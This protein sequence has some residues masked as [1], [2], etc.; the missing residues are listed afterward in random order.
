MNTKTQILIIR[1]GETFAKNTIFLKK[2]L[3]KARLYTF[4]D[5]GHFNQP[6][7]PELLNAILEN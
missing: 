1:G 4:K 6:S 7:F 3:P 2:Y 5:R